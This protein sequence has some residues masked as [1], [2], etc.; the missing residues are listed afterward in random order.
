MRL[1]ITHLR[2]REILSTRI[3]NALA[4]NR[5][6]PQILQRLADR[7]DLEVIARDIESTTTAQHCKNLPVVANDLTLHVRHDKPTILSTTTNQ[8]FE[9]SDVGKTSYRTTT[10]PDQPL[11]SH[12]LS[13]YSTWIHP[14]YPLFSM[15]D[16]FKDYETGGAARCSTFL[17][18]AICAA[19]SH[20]LNPHW[21]SVLG[22]ATDLATLR[23]TLITQAEIQEGLADPK[24]ETTT[25]ALAVMLIVNSYSVQYSITRHAPAEIQDIPFDSTEGPSPSII[26]A[27]PISKSA[28]HTSFP[29]TPF[30]I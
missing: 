17:V 21:N 9:S 8:V 3:L 19:A 23:Q 28:T 22:T 1:E 13:L 7:E 26:E 16:F 30:P 27:Y 2:Q 18:A 15:P 20:F 24:A 14:Q 25:H 5:Q 4:S 29:T 6:V 10:L 12:L 11:L